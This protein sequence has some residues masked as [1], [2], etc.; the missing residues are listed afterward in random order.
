MVK[1]RLMLDSTKTLFLPC[2]HTNK[3]SIYYTVFPPTSG[4]TYCILIPQKH[5]V[6]KQEYT[7]SHSTSFFA[8]KQYD[9]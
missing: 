6:F 3:I 1:F 5:A 2:T 7:Q 9:H 8:Q 4:A